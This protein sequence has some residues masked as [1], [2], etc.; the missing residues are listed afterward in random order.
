[1]CTGIEPLFFGSAATATAA[2]TSGLVGVGGAFSA[3]SAFATGAS[4]LSAISSINKGNQAQRMANYQAAQAQADAQVAREVAQVNADKI[5]RAGKSQQSAARSALAASGVITDVGTPLMIQGE[6]VSNA[7]NDALT[8]LLTGVRAGQQLDY[9]ASGLRV[10][11]RNAKAQGYAG[12]AGSLLTMGAGRSRYLT[13]KAQ[14]SL[15]DSA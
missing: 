2:A 1:M 8:E 4:A 3:A 9:Q 7:E 15:E 5:R 12:A 13:R 10:A 14:P 11:G 6:I